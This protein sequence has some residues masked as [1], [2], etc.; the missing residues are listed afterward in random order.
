[1]S[2]FSPLSKM[3]SYIY[4]FLCIPTQTP[5]TLYPTL[6]RFHPIHRSR[7]LKMHKIKYT[8]PMKFSRLSKVPQAPGANLMQSS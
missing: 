3:I 8:R 1:M 2:N 4:Q 6:M 5:P 7:T